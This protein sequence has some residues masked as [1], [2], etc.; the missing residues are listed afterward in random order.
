MT[1]ETGTGT[2]TGGYKYG[3][4]N[5]EE[6]GATGNNFDESNLYYI[7]EKEMSKREKAM[8]MI[9]LVVPIIIAVLFLGG[10]AFM[11]VHNFGK[12]YPGPGPGGQ[13][14]PSRGSGGSVSHPTSPSHDIAHD[15]G[16]GG[17]ASAP[18][19]VPVPVPRRSVPTTKD[20]GSS[21]AA[22]PKCTDRGLTGEC[23]PTG[24][25]V[26]LECCF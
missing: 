5:D 7:K 14:V 12:L 13:K 21:C 25:G 4:V 17:I 10:L 19:P 22:Y 23:C 8:K 11:L 2:G 16:G 1:N 3:S 20:G 6:A 18:V 15:G 9:K 26:K 24:G